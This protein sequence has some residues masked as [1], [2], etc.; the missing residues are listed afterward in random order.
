MK[1]GMVAVHY[2]KDEHRQ[3]FVGRVSAAGAAVGAAPGC[4][5]ADCWITADGAVVSMAQWEDENAMRESFVAAEKAGVDFTFD[6]REARPRDI[7]RLVS[8]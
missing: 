2:P 1:I 8:P 5:A 7:M 4:L 3:E 6:E